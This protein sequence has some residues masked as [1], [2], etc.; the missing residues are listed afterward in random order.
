[1]REGMA[2]LPELVREATVLLDHNT[3][4]EFVADIPNNV[5]LFPA[6]TLTGQLNP[7]IR[8]LA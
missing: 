2:R 4:A 5:M 7:D 1:M 3:E 6:M 8:G